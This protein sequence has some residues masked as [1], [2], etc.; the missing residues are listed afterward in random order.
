[1]VEET[2]TKLLDAA[3]KVFAEKG[4]ERASMDDVAAEA[5]M[6]KGALYWNFDSKEGLF[7][8]LLD[9]RVYGPLRQLIE[10]T[11]TADLDA[12]P[13]EYGNTVMAGLNAQPGLVAIA[14]DQWLKAH[15]DPEAGTDQA[16]LWRS[17][18]DALA[19]SLHARARHLGA[20]EFDV[21]P[22]RVATAYI[23][24]AHGFGMW[25]LID[26]EIADDEIYGEIC[27]LVYQGLLARALGLLPDQQPGI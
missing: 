23:A 3:A 5:G 22:E 1:M 13:S 4:Y 18:R 6:T 2:R 9:E 8:T 25:R 11:R 17:M 26:P 20:P 27:A 15:R 12:S 21:A 7:H 14:Y 24:L 19:E 16:A 10:F